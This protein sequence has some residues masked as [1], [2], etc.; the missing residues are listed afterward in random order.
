MERLVEV[1]CSFEI[2][3]RNERQGR[4]IT[5]TEWFQMRKSAATTLMTVKDLVQEV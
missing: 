4:I 2:T 5:R 1:T 3:K